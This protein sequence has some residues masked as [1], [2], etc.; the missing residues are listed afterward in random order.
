[1]SPTL[2]AQLEELVRLR[3]EPPAEV[4]AEAL[5]RG[6]ARLYQESILAR[7]LKKQISRQKAIRLVGLEAVKMAEHQWQATQKDLAWGL[8]HG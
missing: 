5:E 2:T 7:F 3:H 6:L 4:L 8:G 1:M